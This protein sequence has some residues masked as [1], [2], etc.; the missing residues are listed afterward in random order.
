MQ[1]HL[2][3]SHYFGTAR[4][5]SDVDFYAADSEQA[6]D[7]LE[8]LAFERLEV[9]RSSGSAIAAIYWRS[10]ARIHVQLVDDVERKERVQRL[11]RDVGLA[12]DLRD[13]TLSRRL[14]QF[15]YKLAAETERNN[16]RSSS[17]RCEATG[18]DPAGRRQGAEGHPRDVL[19]R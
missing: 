2:T 13:K 4:P 8:R 12:N 7:L 14:W 17:A 5:G 10:D 15:A 1:L 6:R 11:L 19:H 18:H 9:D 16:E 3:G